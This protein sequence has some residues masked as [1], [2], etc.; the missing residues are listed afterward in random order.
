MDVLKLVAVFA[1]LLIALKLKAKLFLAILCSIVATV[2]L[3][4]I[5]LLTCAELWWKATK[6]WNNLQVLLVLYFITF[7]QRLLERRSQLKKAQM[8]LNGIFN[9]RR[10]NATIAP[11]F[12]GLLPSGAAARICGEIVDEATAD[13]LNK[14][15][16][17]FVTS[18]FRHI[19]ESFLPTYTSVIIMANL[20][21]VSIPS[22]VIGML[23]VIVILYI[24][25][26][27][28]Y[29]RKV[30]KATGQ[31]PSKNKFKD[32]LNLLGHLWT[33]IVIIFLILAF[34]LPVLAAVGI[35]AIAAI[36]IYR[37]KPKELLPC[38][39]SAF[40]PV[41]IINSYLVLVF[42]EFISEAGVINTLPDLFS[43]L[44]IPAWLIFAIIFFVGTLAAGSNAII[45]MCTVTAFTAIPGSG[46]PE[47]VLLMG[48]SYAAMQITPTHV[49]LTIVVDYFKTNLGGI[50]KKTIPVIA[51]FCVLLSLYYLLLTAI[52]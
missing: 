4:Q 18:F 42:K 7:L 15:E 25:G 41:L 6:D 48:F 8:D 38:V 1:I 36:F 43:T 29:V 19:P 3:W 16:K 20:S 40:E 5:P 2:A 51:C 9:N 14:D 27:V 28:F 17:S 46:M 10:I 47:M 49:C 39:T 24:L 22:F 44:P 31:E 26:Y 33:L 32:F 37:F 23:P 12:I 30:P 35:V 21:G 50:I 45:A 52:I 13:Y 34:N 11:I